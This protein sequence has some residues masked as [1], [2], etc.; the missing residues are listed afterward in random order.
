MDKDKDQLF[1]WF[2][3]WHECLDNSGFDH[4]QKLSYRD[5]II[6]YLGFCKT[7][8]KR[9]TLSSA[10]QFADYY[11]LRYQPKPSDIAELKE[12]IKWF[13]SEARKFRSAAFR[14]L[15]LPA[16]ADLGSTDWEKRLVRRLRNL[17]YL[18]RTEQTYRGWAYPAIDNAQ[19]AIARVV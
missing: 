9:V 19:G 5:K 16:Q 1:I 7:E 6:K 13:F 14:D 2:P 11:K 4:L 17:H 10:R 15:P 12:A 3:Q 8:N 18:W